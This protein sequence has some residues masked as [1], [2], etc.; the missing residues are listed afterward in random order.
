MKKILFSIVALCCTVAAGAQ[1]SSQIASAILQKAEGGPIIYYGVDALKDAYNAADE[2]GG[3]ITLTSG[4]FN[5]PGEI[6]KSV[7]IYGVGF[8][9]N[10]YEGMQRTIISNYVTFIS[11]TEGNVLQNAK[12]E[13]VFVNAAIYINKV[14]SLTIAKCQFNGLVFN[15]AAVEVEGMLVRQCYINGGVDAYNNMIDGLTINNCYISGW[16]GRTIAGSQILFNHCLLTPYSSYTDNSI[17]TYT[18]CIIND[19]GTLGANSYAEKNI[20]THMDV[21][22][23]NVTSVGNYAVDES[24]LF[25]DGVNSVG[26]TTARTFTLAAPDTYK[27]TDG[28]TVGLTGGDYPWYK[29]PSLPYVKDLNATVNGTNLDV[30]YKA[31]VGS[32][33]PPTE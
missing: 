8:E 3:T 20:F 30:D 12:L 6:K 13:G 24:S 17:A 25:G 26:Y 5:S 9:D 4:T 33:N 10:V 32:T 16:V 15:G 23:S 21:N 29:V 27:G 2:T 7:A 22:P 19:N 28:T 11:D 14:S 1:N 18:N 31:G